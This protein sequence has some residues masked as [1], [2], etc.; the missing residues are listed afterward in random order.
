[1]Y[2]GTH[3]HTHNKKAM[4]TTTQS[5]H[6]FHFANGTF[7]FGAVFVSSP[8]LLPRAALCSNQLPAAS[9][10]RR[11]YRYYSIRTVTG[12]LVFPFYYRHHSRNDKKLASSRLTLDRRLVS[13][14]P[15]PDVSA[16]GSQGDASSNG[17]DKAVTN[18]RRRKEAGGSVGIFR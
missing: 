3:T 12:Y 15:P 7:W 1:M 13:E 6:H 14:I 17:K 10:P 16:S 18:S 2:W 11:P 9:P 8:A 5:P 4:T